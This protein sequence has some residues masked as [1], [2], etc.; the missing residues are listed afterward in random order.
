[1]LSVIIGFGILVSAAL[2]APT[3]PVSATS[4]TTAAQ[5]TISTPFVA[6]V[7]MLVA[8]VVGGVIYTVARMF[9]KKAVH[10]DEEKVEAAVGGVDP[11]GFSRCAALYFVCEPTPVVAS[12]SAATMPFEGEDIEE[13]E[14]V[15]RCVKTHVAELVEEHCGD[16][17]FEV[18]VETDFG[19]PV[20]HSVE[21]HAVQVVQGHRRDKSVRI[22][23][24]DFPVWG[25]VEDHVVK[26]VEPH[27]GDRPLEVLFEEAGE[28]AR[29]ADKVSAGSVTRPGTLDVVF[30]A[31]NAP[32]KAARM[33]ASVKAT[34]V[35]K[36]GKRSGKKIRRSRIGKENER[37]AF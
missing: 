3:S 19:A 26:R 10:V 33:R 27:S 1:M 18:S 24:E 23:V 21:A 34:C 4:A 13:P 16:T 20:L 12:A 29:M 2:A 8:S 28:A 36:S 9:S 25:Y 32:K 14:P 6:L 17:S 37:V 35:P 7:V 30:A 31:H 22:T 5:I 11:I 15:W